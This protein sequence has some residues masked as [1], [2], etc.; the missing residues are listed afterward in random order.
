MDEGNL[1][2]PRAEFPAARTRRRARNPSKGESL[3]HDYR[4]AP[5]QT[6]EQRQ[7]QAKLRAEDD[8][9][10][11]FKCNLFRFW[12]ACHEKR[13]RRARTCAGDMHACF[14]HHWRAL[15]EE[16]RQWG[17][18]LLAALA[19]GNTIE[20]AID[21]ADAEAARFAAFAEKLRTQAAGVGA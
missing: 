21:A 14:E 9:M 10:A 18:A 16:E 17:R 4:F 11:R 3:P 15:T 20:A 1:M 5:W 6:P 2:K 7:F 12:R 19:A 13:C 8:A